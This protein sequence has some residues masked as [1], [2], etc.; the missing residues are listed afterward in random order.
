MAA[1]TL[2]SI[3]GNEFSLSKLENVQQ[4]RENCVYLAIIRL[5]VHEIFFA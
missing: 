1:L 4:S 2:K 5:F 3:Y